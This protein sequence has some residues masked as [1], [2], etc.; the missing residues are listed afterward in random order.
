MTMHNINKTEH[1]RTEHV[2]R[3]RVVERRG[4]RSRRLHRLED[5]E[6]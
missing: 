4:N 2:Q 1:D 6:V 5:E 3:A